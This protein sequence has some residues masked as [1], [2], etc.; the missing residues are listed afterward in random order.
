[1]INGPPAMV[2]SDAKNGQLVPK[3]TM[4][5]QPCRG[6]PTGSPTG[7]YTGAAIEVM[8]EGQNLKVGVFSPGGVRLSNDSLLT[9]SFPIDVPCN[10]SD[11]GF[12][13]DLCPES[14]EFL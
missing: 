11:D 3:D 7:W 1:M 8:I 14:H 6:G 4:T 13:R 12:C 9:T 10:E 2:G 5:A